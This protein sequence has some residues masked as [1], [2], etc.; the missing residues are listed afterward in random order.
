MSLA[1]QIVIAFIIDLLLGDPKG[2]PH[3]V[4]IIARLAY[5]T[6]NLCRKLLSNHK[7]AG[8]ISTI[9]IVATSFLGVWLI[10]QGLAYIHPMLGLFASIYFIYTTLSIR[11]L[12]DESRPV[13]TSLRKP[14]SLKP[15]RV[16]QE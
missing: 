8:I 6:E 4:K 15:V 11:S 16:C 2:Y 1:I 14:T 3:P 5:G 13:F 7:L 9:T 12:F 10:I